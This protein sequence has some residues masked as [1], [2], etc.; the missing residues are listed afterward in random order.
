MPVYLDRT[1]VRLTYAE[2]LRLAMHATFAPVPRPVRCTLRHTR[3]AQNQIL[4]CTGAKLVYCATDRTWA[5]Y[6]YAPS[7]ADVHDAL[8]RAALTQ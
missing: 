7:G 4:L 3:L 1:Y 8:R 5:V 6:G 2:A